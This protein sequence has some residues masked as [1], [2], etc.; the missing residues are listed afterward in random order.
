MWSGIVHKWVGLR[1]GLSCLAGRRVH[2]AHPSRGEAGAGT[3]VG[4]ERRPP[5]DTADGS[6]KPPLGGLQVAYRRGPI[7]GLLLISVLAFGC[8]QTPPSPTAAVLAATAGADVTVGAGGARAVPGTVPAFAHVWVLVLENASFATLADG[9]SDPYFRSL[10][11]KYG[12]AANYFAVAHPSQPN[13]LA[14]FSGST[15]GVT[16]DGTHNLT[17]TNLT[18]Q[19]QAHGKTWR[20]YEQDYPGGCFAGPTSGGLGEGFGAAGLYA[21]K[22]DPA[23]SFDNIRTNSARCAN[24]TSLSSFDP[25]AADFE[26]IVPNGCNDMHS[27]PM[28]TADAFL[29]DF[30]PHMTTGPAF[31]NSVLFITTDEGTGAN[32]VATLVISPLA[33]AGFSS[34]VRHDHYSLVR[35]IEDAWGLGCLGQACN[36]NDM[37]EFFN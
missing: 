5:I 3:R 29:A 19:L 37:S 12:L 25:A 9:S 34:S 18:D 13:Y 10:M 23:I 1:I 6:L 27:C 8:S 32:Q 4:G 33:R 17:G 28:A 15:Q 11:S 22:H 26:L 24:I 2:I 30:V 7:V 20:V 35:T 36:A 16:D 14:L 21:R 31:A